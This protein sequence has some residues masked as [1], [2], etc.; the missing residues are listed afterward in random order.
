MNLLDKLLRPGASTEDVDADAYVDPVNRRDY[1]AAVPLLKKAMHRNDARAIGLFAAMKALGNGVD[2]DP[3]EAGALFRQAAERGDVPSQAAL[4]MCL[5]SGR[6]MP[7][8]NEEAAYWLH[9]A[10]KAFSMQA[11]EVLGSLVHGDNFEFGEHFTEDEAYDLSAW[12]RLEA[13]RGQVAAQAALGM[14]LSLGLG[15]PVNNKEAAYW[16]YR[17]GK[18]GSNQAIL[19]LGNLAF[20][21][22]S[23]VG[24]HFTEDELCKLVV[25]LRKASAGPSVSRPAGVR[26]H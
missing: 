3:V 22:N 19:F 20:K 14:C 24:P 12:F 13:N 16:L 7:A 25:K 11:I 9:R 8:N 2:K 15:A 17:A 4:G 23:V 21:D 1:A 5:A 10:A 26:L 18:A 6:G